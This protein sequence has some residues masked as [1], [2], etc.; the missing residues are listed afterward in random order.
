MC[1]CTHTHAESQ[2]IKEKVLLVLARWCFV[3][4]TNWVLSLGVCVHIAACSPTDG[5]MQIDSGIQTSWIDYHC[6]L[7]LLRGFNQMWYWTWWLKSTH[8]FDYLTSLFQNNLTR[9]NCFLS[10]GEVEQVS[11][12]T[13]EENIGFGCQL[14]ATNIYVLKQFRCYLCLC[15]SLASVD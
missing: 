11:S 12:H 5:I 4:F 15:C 1:T 9:N 7:H 3:S 13:S 10:N 2:N 8:P 14:N 6:P